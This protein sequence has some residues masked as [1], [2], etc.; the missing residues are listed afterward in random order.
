[1]TAATFKISQDVKIDGFAGHVVGT[2]DDPRG[3]GPIGHNEYAIR[4]SGG[5]TLRYADEIEAA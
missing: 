5:V 1:M 3:F 4:T 2:S